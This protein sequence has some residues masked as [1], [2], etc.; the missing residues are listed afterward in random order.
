MCMCQWWDDDDDD[1]SE[2]MRMNNINLRGNK[3][4]NA[5][6]CWSKNKNDIFGIGTKGMCEEGTKTSINTRECRVR[7]SG[8]E[9][10][11]MEG[12]L[13]RALVVCVSVDEL[14]VSLLFLRVD[15][16]KWQNKTIH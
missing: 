15:K 1:E 5:A 14:K 4:R 13:M 9:S 8:R 7:A 11:G 16:L 3:G 2:L 10:T 6:A 12:R